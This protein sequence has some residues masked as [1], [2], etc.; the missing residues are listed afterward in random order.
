[1]TVWLA[2]MFT[3][4]HYRLEF[5][6]RQSADNAHCIKTMEGEVRLVSSSRRSTIHSRRCL[7][8]QANLNTKNA[9]R[10]PRPM[11]LRCVALPVQYTS[12]RVYWLCTRY[13]ELAH[14][15]HVLM[16][17]A[18]Q[19]S[20]HLSLRGTHDEHDLGRRLMERLGIELIKIETR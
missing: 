17:G 5:G 4:Y 18:C 20:S 9:G 11:H 6:R 14:T 13:R 15:L 2:Q 19:R 12:N 1:M 3:V 16:H 7:T 10:L 8:L